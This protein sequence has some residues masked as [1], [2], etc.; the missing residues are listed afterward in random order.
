MTLLLLVN[1]TEKLLEGEWDKLNL[2]AEGEV[3]I[4][5]T[6]ETTKAPPFT[7]NGGPVP[8]C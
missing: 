4:N 3:G 7:G 2:P 6:F 5:V 1:D 8:Y